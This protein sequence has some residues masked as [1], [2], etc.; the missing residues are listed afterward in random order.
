MRSEVLQPT[1]SAEFH[2]V[3]P[4]TAMNHLGYTRS[5]ESP[6]NCGPGLLYMQQKT[7]QLSPV[8]ASAFWNTTFCF[9]PLSFG[10]LLHIND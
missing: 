6:N 3:V 2:L 9:E 5:D 4:T 1:A 8:Q 10:S 7:S